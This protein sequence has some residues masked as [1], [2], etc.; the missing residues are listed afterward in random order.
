MERIININLQGRVI[1]IEETA[2]NSLK[3]YIDSLRRHFANEEG[4]EE[5]ISDIEYRIAEL[6]SHRLKQGANCIN[7]NDLGTIINSIGRIDEIEAAEGDENRSGKIPPVQPEGA[8]FIK[9]PFFRNA[10][11]KIIAGVCSGIANRTSVDPVLVRVIFVLLFG[12]LIWIYLLLWIIV[13][14]QSSRSN[15][16]RR[17]YRNPDDKV[18]AGVCG[19]LAVY[20]RTA[21]WVPRL[22]FALPLFISV[23]ST[24]MH[25]FWWHWPTFLGPRI[26]T[27]GFGSTLFI[28]YVI[29]WIALPYASST[30]DK[31]EMRGERIDLNSIKVASQANTASAYQQKQYGGSGFG[32]I[33]GILFKAFF[34]FIGGIIALSF[35][36]ALIGLVFGGIVAMPFTGFILDSWVENALMWSGIILFLGIPFLALITWIIRRLVGVRSQR[37]Y[38]GYVFVCLWLVGFVSLLTLS[39]IFLRN[40]SSKSGIEEQVAIHQPSVSRL[41]VSA[42]DGR[43]RGVGSYHFGWT[44]DWEGD[45]DSFDNSDAPF[46]IISK[47]SLWLNTVK[48]NVVQSADSFYHIYETKMSRG[49]T[50]EDA[51]KLATHISFPINQLDSSIFLPAG[52]TISCKDK[53]RNQQ[54]MVTVEVPMGKELHFGKD[55]DGYKWFNINVNRHRNFYF[56]RG[57]DDDG[58]ENN[59]GYVMTS[60]GLKNM[61][62]QETVDTG[63]SKTTDTVEEN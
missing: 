17:L 20:L 6:L 50:A 34:M 8:P 40:F 19:G 44:N 46:R 51:K 63:K 7:S 45:D 32:H 36:G 26:F 15:I 39:G 11:D 5:I 1:P 57:W 56:E 30:T 2:Y 35:F 22:I 55:L 29:L 9:G 60:S 38:L 25:V 13:P 37:H 4:S 23:V 62:T 61:R 28:L 48:V 3:Q 24:G 42:L 27:G 10:D 14:S 53:F 58:Y 47:D 52:F 33:I 49:C 31:L 12:A 16:T 18:I 54:V 41:Y 21:S 43:G 59:T